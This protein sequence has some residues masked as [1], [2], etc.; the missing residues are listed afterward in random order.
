MMRRWERGEL[1]YREHI[2]DGL[3]NARDALS[4]LFDGSNRG[5]LLVKIR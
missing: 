5:K 4:K 1:L 3:E 2:I